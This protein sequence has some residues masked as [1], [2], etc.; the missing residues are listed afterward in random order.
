MSEGSGNTCAS[1]RSS[2][3]RSVSPPSHVRVRVQALEQRK[4]GSLQ[5]R[6]LQHSAAGRRDAQAASPAGAAT[7]PGGT[8]GAELSAGQQPEVAG[9]GLGEG[10]GHQ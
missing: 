8:C 9:T 3:Q 4:R 2:S 10:S 1:G 7:C 5:A 6:D